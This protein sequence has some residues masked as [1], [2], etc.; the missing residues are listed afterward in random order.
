VESYRKWCLDLNDSA[1]PLNSSRDR[2][3]TYVMLVLTRLGK[4]AS[5]VQK[6]NK[7]MKQEYTK[8]AQ[9]L[10]E[11]KQGVTKQLEAAARLL[12]GPGVAG[13]KL[14]ELERKKTYDSDEVIEYVLEQ[15]DLYKELCPTYAALPTE[16]QH[17]IRRVFGTRFQLAQ[18]KQGEIPP[19]SFK[20]LLEDLR[21]QDLL[22]LQRYLYLTIFF[23]TCRGCKTRGAL[24]PS[25]RTSVLSVFTASAHRLLRIL[26][27]CIEARESPSLPTQ[28]LPDDTEHQFQRMYMQFLEEDFREK[29]MDLN[30]IT[31]WTKLSQKHK[32]AAMR[33]LAMTRHT[34]TNLLQLMSVIQEPPYTHLVDQLSGQDTGKSQIMLMY[35]PDLVRLTLERDPTDVQGQTI[36]WL[37]ES[38]AHIFRRAKEALGAHP[39]KVQWQGRGLFVVALSQLI[40]EIRA[41]GEGWKGGKQL[42]HLVDRCSV[43]VLNRTCTE[44]QLELMPM[45]VDDLGCLQA[46]VTHLNQTLEQQ[47][48]KLDSLL[49]V[50]TS[51]VL[52]IMLSCEDDLKAQ[53]VQRDISV[54][55]P[56]LEVL[57]RSVSAQVKRNFLEGSSG[58]L[59]EASSLCQRNDD[60]NL[61]PSNSAIWTEQFSFIQEGKEVLRKAGAQAVVEKL[62]ATDLA[63]PIEANPSEIQPGMDSS[64]P[65]PDPDADY[66]NEVKKTAQGLLHNLD[67]AYYQQSC[68]R[69]H[70]AQADSG[71]MAPSSTGKGSHIML[72]YSWGNKRSNGNFVH[73]EKMGQL[74]NTL[75]AQGFTVWWDVKNMGANI[76]DGMVQAIDDACVVII[77]F[78][79]EYFKSANCRKEAE[80]TSNSPHVMNNIIWL[81]MDPSYRATGWLKML[82]GNAR[83]IDFYDKRTIESSWPDVLSQC[84]NFAKVPPVPSTSASAAV[85]SKPAQMEEDQTEPDQHKWSEQP[86]A[87]PSA[88]ANNTDSDALEAR[89]QKLEDFHKSLDKIAQVLE[90]SHDAIAATAGTPGGQHENTSARSVHVSCT[91]TIS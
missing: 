56:A 86:E 28:V 69:L 36:V 79:Q 60:G 75:T 30:G 32:L 85:V 27:E 57:K 21:S 64:M 73:Q 1:Q 51:K 37:L 39:H 87:A 54:W 44:G 29:H 89:I 31:V 65:L 26:K 20:H 78:S 7:H 35:C 67:P 49:L 22:M 52:K 72:S 12:E 46:I 48:D 61:L 9:K 5:V 53:I 66:E 43:R 14:Q 6:V 38:L 71:G 55:V 74:Y 84:H 59:C 4:S 91:C 16:D 15:Q 11:V 42:H 88:S 77:G 70:T 62:L 83:Y 24:V 8:R 3:C 23:I 34:Y 41:R 47:Q 17:S 25:V 10:E 50:E 13:E 80:Y 76:L 19:V 68:S 81:R 45:D 18:L 40:W 82:Q 33:I 90:K 58:D 2:L 63:A